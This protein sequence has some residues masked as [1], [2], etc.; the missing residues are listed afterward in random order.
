M[1]INQGRI[2]QI[3]KVYNQNT[4]V[5]QNAKPEKTQGLMGKK[6]Q[7]TLSNEGQTFQKVLSAMEQLPDIREDKV[8]DVKQRVD[9]G[10]YQIDNEKVAEKMM[11]AKLFNGLGTRKK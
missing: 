10:T 11:A 1:Y 5:S 6:D 7:L 4:K 8:K 9:S 2:G 3:M